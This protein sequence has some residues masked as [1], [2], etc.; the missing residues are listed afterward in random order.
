[1]KADNA[2]SV[3]IGEGWEILAS[4]HLDSG[5]VWRM[6]PNPEVL[7][8]TLPWVINTSAVP[9]DMGLANKYVIL[10]LRLA[11]VAGGLENGKSLSDFPEF[12]AHIRRLT[13]FR[14][15]TEQFW[16]EGSF[17]DDI[18]LQASGA[19][20][21]VYQ[22]DQRV[23]IM[24]ANLSEEASTFQ[25]DLDGSRYGIEPASFSLISSNGKSEEKISERK[26]STVVGSIPLEPFELAAVIFEKRKPG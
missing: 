10:G 3:L 2:E 13:D 1:M 18:G 19:F 11:I 9:V 6:P 23:A 17:Q 26:G 12:A 24:A 7:Q 4:Q 15:K 21:K 8:Y 16:F 25:F 14:K 5:W 22:T 20:A